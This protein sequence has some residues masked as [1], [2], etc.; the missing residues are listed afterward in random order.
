MDT[1]TPYNGCLTSEQFLF[2]EMRIVAKQY[3]EGKSL[4]EIIKE[5][6]AENLF[7]YPTERKLAQH[8]RACYRR[9]AALGN[10]KLVL[11]LAN[12]PRVSAKQINLYAMMRSNRLVREFMINLIGGKYRASAF[13]YCRERSL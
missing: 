10:A 3:A 7:Q 6:K 1:I 12:A 2:Y 8:A 5:V 13:Y 9:L 11:E 4:D